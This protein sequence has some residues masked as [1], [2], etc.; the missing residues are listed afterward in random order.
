MVVWVPV[1]AMRLSVIDGN[2]AFAA[3]GVFPHRYALHVIGVHA[4]PVS[5]QVVND[6]TVSDLPFLRFVKKTMRFDALAAA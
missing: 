2:R 6:Q 4:S 5:A 3:Y 1:R